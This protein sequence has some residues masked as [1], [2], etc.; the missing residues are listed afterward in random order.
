MRTLFH[1]SIFSFYIGHLIDEID[2]RV[3]Q[4]QFPKQI[5]RN[6]RQFSEREYFKAHEWKN[7]LLYVAYPVLNGILPT[8]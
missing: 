4:I 3:A 7:I 8:R 1:S 2:R 5:R 6:L